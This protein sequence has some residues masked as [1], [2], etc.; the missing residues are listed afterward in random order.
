MILWIFVACFQSVAFSLTEQDIIKSVLHHYPLIQEAEL[1]QNASE[2]EVESAM[3]QFDH[4]LKFKSR[5][6]IEDKY[7]NQYFETVIQRQLPLAGIELLAGHRQGRGNFPAYDGKFKTSGAGEIFAGMSFP[8][9]RN[10]ATDEYR[11]NLR[12]SE[13]D[14]EQAKSELNLK[15]IMSIHKALSL[16]YKWVLETQKLK[17][18]Q[19]I[20]ALA[21]DRQKMMTKQFAAGAIERIKIV[22]NERS[23]DKRTSEV[24]KGQIEVNKLKAELGIY[25]RD[26]TGQSLVIDSSISPESVLKHQ[27]SIPSFNS[28]LVNPQV[29]ILK[30]E[31]EKLLANFKFNDQ[32]K[33]PGLNLDVLGAKELSPNAA[34]DPESL[35]LGISFDFPLENRKFSGKSTSLTYKIEALE[36]RRDLLNLELQRMFVF[37]VDAAKTSF[38]R[39]NVTNSEFEKSKK[40]AD[41]EKIKFNQGGTDLFIVNL[42]EQ[43][44]AD[45]DIRRWTA[46]YEYHQYILDARL[47]SASFPL[48]AGI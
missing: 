20:L 29:E 10:R 21:Q 14:R 28:D 23:I 39:W 32:S 31:R 15:K 18:N 22:D 25:L 7:E 5:N 42:R 2:S 3:G 4:K 37:Y 43:D 33:L 11:T 17:I 27:E 12:L 34:Y 45:V 16:F 6:R 41:A 38:N 35:Q 40:M 47:F 13:L 8:I 24:I 44:V 46:L 1:K 9:L 19:E 36:R 30:L 48:E 26:D